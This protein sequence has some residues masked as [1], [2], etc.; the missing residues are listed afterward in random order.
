[1]PHACVQNASNQRLLP[2]RLVTLGCMLQAPSAARKWRYYASE[3]PF[4][5]SEGSEAS[6][7]WTAVEA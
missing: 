2:F 5:K 3:Y 7:W 6:M 4:T 1:M